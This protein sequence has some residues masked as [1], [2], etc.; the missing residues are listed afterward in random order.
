MSGASRRPEAFEFATVELLLW[1][2]V[3]L[4]AALAVLALA[5]RFELGVALVLATLLL[6]TLFME[7]MPG[8]DI[9]IWVYPKDIIFCL[10]LCAATI[11]LLPWRWQLRRARW[12]GVLLLL[13]FLLGFLR[14][15]PLYSL[16]A[17]GNE[18][19]GYFPFLAALLY[20]STFKYDR[21]RQS[22]LITIW[23]AGSVALGVVTVFR[24]LAANLGLSIAN[25]WEAVLGAGS[26]RVIHCAHGFYLATAFFFS[27]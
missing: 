3:L 9:G 27:L 24:W 25:Q 10:L 19:R 6:D 4:A 8:I 12:I 5:R 22:H 1:F 2:G 17:V 23:L 21:R 13:M 14:G 16:K 15:L 26:M 20:F 7:T 18:T 11:R